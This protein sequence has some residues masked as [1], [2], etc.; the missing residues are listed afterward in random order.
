MTGVS[1]VGLGLSPKF[2]TE[3]GLSV[4]RNSDIIFL[5]GYTSTSCGWNE[6]LIYS[7]VGKPV[8]KI[9]RSDLE[10]RGIKKILA[11]AK[12][13]SIAIA[14][15]GDPLI[16]T[17]HSIIPISAREEGINFSIVPG[18]SVHCYIIS[19]SMLSSYKFGKSVTIV[20]G[21]DPTPYRVIKENHE[22]GLHTILYM[23]LKED[24][25]MTAG[26]AMELLLEFEKSE[27]GHIVYPDTKV[28]VGSQLGCDN[29]TV[30]YMDINQVV[31]KYKTGGPHIVI[32]PSKLSSIEEEALKC[33]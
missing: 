14:V 31:Y 17:T 27:G 7:M 21:K 5:D 33:L 11:I 18:V 6:A 12:E 32:F 22:R 1:L 10:G 16:S 3:A 26:R 19:K 30:K 24:Y 13:K 2:L 23:D 9:Y 25:Y 29:E 15:V 20:E 28:I 4:M 8:T